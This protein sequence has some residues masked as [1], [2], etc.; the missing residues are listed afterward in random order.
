MLR[1]EVTP[2]YLRYMDEY[3][4]EVIM[5]GSLSARQSVLM[6]YLRVH[7]AIMFVA[8]VFGVFSAG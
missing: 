7:P 5:F 1:P 8:G 3:F 4:L 6:E 2:N